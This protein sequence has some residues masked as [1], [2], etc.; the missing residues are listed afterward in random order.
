MMMLVT[1]SIALNMAAFCEPIKRTPDWNN[2]ALTIELIGN[3][4]N[5]NKI[6]VVFI[7]EG[8]TIKLNPKPMMIDTT[9]QTKL[10]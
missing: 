8:Q 5:V 9:K 1:G 4:A 3:T 10:V 2:N 6:P 7:P